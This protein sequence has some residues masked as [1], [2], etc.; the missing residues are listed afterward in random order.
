MAAISGVSAAVRIRVK[1]GDD[2]N[3]TD[4]KGRSALHLAASRGHI[5]T[6]KVLLLAGADPTACDHAGNDAVSV[7]LASGRNEVVELVREHC[8]PAQVRLSAVPEDPV[9]ISDLFGNVQPIQLELVER[10]QEQPASSVDGNDHPARQ[11]RGISASQLSVVSDVPPSAEDQDA[12]SGMIFGGWDAEPEPVRPVADLSVAI[13]AGTIQTAISTHTVIDHDAEWDEIAIDLP[14][15]REVRRRRT[16]P[17]SEEQES[18]RNTILVALRHGS[19]AEQWIGEVTDGDKGTQDPEFASNLKNVLSDFGVSVEE[20]AWE[21][22]SRN[23]LNNYDRQTEDDADDALEEL[24]ALNSTDADPLKHYLKAFPDKK[25][26]LT[27]EQEGEL[28][29]A[30]EEGVSSAV[31]VAAGCGDAVRMIL[32]AGERVLSGAINSESVFNRSPPGETDI[33]GESGEPNQQALVAPEDDVDIDASS[34]L[35]P[36]LAVQLAQIRQTLVASDASQ[37]SGRFALLCALRLS[38]SY[39]EDV[40]QALINMPDARETGLAMARG[41]K[42]ASV[43]RLRMT[44]ANLRLVLSIAKKYQN[45]GLPFSDLLQEGNI[46]LLKAVEKFD[47]RLGFK[48]S[49]YA[50]WWI[51]QAVTRALA[52]QGRMIRVPVHMVEILNQV[53]RISRQIEGQTGKVPQPATIGAGLS[54]EAAKVSKVLKARHE[55]VS[56]DDL[57]DD[58]HGHIDAFQ[59]LVDEKLNPEESAMRKALSEAIHGVL[60]GLSL[61]ERKVLILRFGLDGNEP[62]TLEQV[63]DIFD[64]TRERIRQIEAKA[65]RRLSHPNRTTSLLAFVAKVPKTRKSSPDAEPDDDA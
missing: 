3:A 24:L 40:A 10:A 41:L 4:D 37:H 15:Y 6:C 1:R 8:R 54:M 35:L 47:Y 18:V 23:G 60:A 55:F 13:A 31:D 32:A 9:A 21:W 5:E 17:G 46:G 39:L 63:G 12:Y 51:R 57:T 64:V 33:V 44:T 11:T 62:H 26:L 45:R 61:R 56:L 14:E 22:Q 36:D 27:R 19:V 65:M 52:D 28:A 53:E 42:K 20:S 7:A 43:A 29:K 58:E 50:T 2:V 49:T 25:L 34:A 48:F 30:I 59:F 16:D 38:W